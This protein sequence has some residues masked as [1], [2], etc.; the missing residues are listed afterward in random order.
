VV[1]I[2][3]SNRGNL[4]KVLGE[5]MMLIETD[6]RTSERGLK[7]AHAENAEET[8]YILNSVFLL[9]MMKT[10]LGSVLERRR[11]VSDPLTAEL[12][13]ISNGEMWGPRGRSTKFPQYGVSGSSTCRPRDG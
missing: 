10:N 4:S 9:G 7:L 6:K 5:L 12:K 2:D 8:F 1:V 13:P 3:E 11:M